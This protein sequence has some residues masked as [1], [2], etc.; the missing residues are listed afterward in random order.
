MFALPINDPV[1]DT[2]VTFAVGNVISVASGHD[3]AVPVPSI[4]NCPD[5][6]GIDI[7][8]FTVPPTDNVLSDGEK[9]T[10]PKLSVCN[11]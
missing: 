5:D 2:A 8:P 7:V 11:P 6:P 4:D 1:N 9:L 3:I 10:C